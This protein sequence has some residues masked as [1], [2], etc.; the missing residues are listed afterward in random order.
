MKRHTAEHMKNVP[1]VQILDALVPHMVDNV[2]DAT[3]RLDRP[4]AEQV[5]AVPKISCSSCSSRAAVRKCRRSSIFLKQPIAESLT[6][7]FLVVRHF[8]GRAG[9]R[10]RC[11]RL[12]HWWQHGDRGQRRG[13]LLALP[14]AFRWSGTGECALFLVYLL[15]LWQRSSAL[16]AGVTAGARLWTSLCHAAMSSRLLVLCLVRRWL[17]VL[18]LMPG[19]GRISIFL[20]DGVPGS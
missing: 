9:V 18:R 20:R 5:I 16:V 12:W 11:R 6:S 10:V 19:F 8:P 15:I 14:V 3:R 7:Q 1:Y 2:M 4:I 17:H 13:V